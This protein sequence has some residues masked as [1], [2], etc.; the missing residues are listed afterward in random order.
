VEPRFWSLVM[1]PFLISPAINFT[2]I[3]VAMKQD[4]G[5]SP[6]EVMR[7]AHP[8]PIFERWVGD[9]AVRGASGSGSGCQGQS[10]GQA[11]LVAPHTQV[12]MFTADF[13]DSAMQWPVFGAG[14]R[15]CAGSVY[16]SN[17]LQIMHTQL[18][19]LP[20]FQ[21]EKNH[22]FSGRHND[23]SWSYTELIYFWKTV[24]NVI[25]SGSGK[26]VVATTTAATL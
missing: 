25:S 24:A 9:R 19:P 4:P 3:A 1:Q 10:Q 14:A 13:K 26:R 16:A 7:S 22:R 8:F 23:T 12:I 5:R 2:D 21:P 20:A 15:A 11:V 18:L 17:L 6:E